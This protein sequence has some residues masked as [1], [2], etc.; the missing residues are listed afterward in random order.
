VNTVSWRMP[1]TLQKDA[2]PTAWASAEPKV[3]D[4]E[5]AYRQTELLIVTLRTGAAPRILLWA[6]YRRQASGLVCVATVLVERSVVGLRPA[7]ASPVLLP[8]VLEL[9]LLHRSRALELEVSITMGIWW[10]E[11]QAVAEPL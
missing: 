7:P 1:D 2:V 4:L 11:N 10:L 6:L 5:I 3:R 8:S 9:S